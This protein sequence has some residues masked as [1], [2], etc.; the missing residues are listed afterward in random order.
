M[1]ADMCVTVTKYS[2]AIGE[3]RDGRNNVSIPW[4]HDEASNMFIVLKGE[5]TYIQN[6]RLTMQVVQ[7]NTVL[8]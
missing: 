4:I 3:K 1:A 7:G 6:G 5:N 8:V 2:H